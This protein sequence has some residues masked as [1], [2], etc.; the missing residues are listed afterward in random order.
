MGQGP[1]ARMRLKHSKDAAAQTITARQIKTD[2]L[3]ISSSVGPGSS[4]VAISNAYGK[5]R[6]LLN[7][8]RIAG[9]KYWIGD[10]AR[11][12]E[13]GSFVWEGGQRTCPDPYMLSIAN[14]L[15]NA[16]NQQVELPDTVPFAAT[17]D[18]FQAM[19]VGING[20][21]SKTAND[22]EIE[23]KSAISV[24]P[25]LFIAL[26]IDLVGL[27]S[28]A[29][30]GWQ[31][32]RLNEQELGYH[33]RL[34]W[35]LNALR[36]DSGENSYFIVPLNGNPD[37]GIEANNVAVTYN[38]RRIPGMTGITSEEISELN[39]LEAERLSAVSGGATRFTG[40]SFNDDLH[41]AWKQVER[42]LSF[43]KRNYSYSRPPGLTPTPPNLTPIDGGLA[44][45]N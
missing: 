17:P 12:L 3:V 33:H 7:D 35:H 13:S 11:Q 37:L 20:L 5:A 43:N 6:S 22:D 28:A 41:A 34:R 1:I 25:I 8:G 4:Q 2:A 40:Y 38:L 27:V 45:S 30:V 10:L 19:S 21:F 14:D 24:L 16:L 18:L 42:V 26:I 29:M 23:K 44:N 32:S 36:W 31:P 9:I 39:S 15:I